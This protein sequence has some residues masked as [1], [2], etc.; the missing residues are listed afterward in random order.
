ML[1]ERNIREDGAWQTINAPT[2]TWR[3]TDGNFHYAK[4]TSE[5]RKRI[6]HV[7]V[8]DKKDPHRVVTVLFDR[9]LQN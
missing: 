6:L 9:R 1:A 3:G 4:Q 2:Q 8:D 7:V 5:K